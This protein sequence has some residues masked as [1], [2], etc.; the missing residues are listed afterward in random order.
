MRRKLLRALLPVLMVGLI[1]LGLVAVGKATRQWLRQQERATVAFVDIDCEPPPG[2]Q[3][4]LFLLE[5]QSL[6][7]LPDRLLLLEE[8]LAGQLADAFGR[9]PWVE[10][11]ERVVLLP[12]RQVQVRL[13][14]RTPVLAVLV[15]GEVRVVD[16]SGVLLPP[17][18]SYEG[19]PLFRGNAPTPAGLSGTAWGDAGVAAAAR[20]AGFLR[21][22]QTALHLRAVEAM[23]AGTLVCFTAAGTR[24]VWGHAPGAETADE[25]PA[26]RKLERLRAAG[27]LDRQA[28][29]DVQREG[30]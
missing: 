9:H 3:R 25:T 4:E 30:Q 5:V 26:A 13:S 14:Y 29:L 22:H 24:I 20:L 28:V 8:N 2:V 7:G 21:P 15:D 12:P 17:Q 1:L 6:G 11:V 19:L 16:A 18:T 23:P 10:K 27:D